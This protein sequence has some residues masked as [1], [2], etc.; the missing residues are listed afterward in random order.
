[1]AIRSILIYG[2]A[3]NPPHKGHIALLNAAIEG[4]HPDRTLVI[5]TKI[6]PH[7]QGGGV[8]FWQRFHMCRCFLSLPGVRRSILEWLLPG[9]SYTL[10]TVKRLKKRHPGAGIFL[11]IGTDMLATFTEWYHYKELLAAC[12]L[13][14]GGREGDDDAEI[15][16]AASALEA[17]GG[18]VALLRH[19]PFE[20]SSTEIRRAFAETGRCDAVTP[21]VE[22][23]II[24]NRLYG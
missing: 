12:T 17:E 10:N 19:R 5:P 6:S 22:A 3:F 16:A 15:A 4:V 11:L 21:E 23:Y 8:S 7:K 24:R 2:G 20:I 18:R 1:M 13:V 9:K 14:A